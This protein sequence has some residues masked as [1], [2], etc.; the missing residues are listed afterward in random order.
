V[1]VFRACTN[2]EFSGTCLEMYITCPG[3]I[4]LNP[5]WQRTISS[6]RIT[7]SRVRCR[8]WV[9]SGCNSDGILVPYSNPI[10]NLA[11]TNYND[12]IVAFDCYL[13]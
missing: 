2:S 5:E 4:V 6:V 12:R 8:F 11:A 13:A 3:C 10:Y 1:H 7:D 9:T